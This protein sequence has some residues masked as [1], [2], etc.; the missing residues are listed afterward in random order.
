MLFHH[1]QSCWL[2]TLIASFQSPPSALR[3]LQYRKACYLISH[4][5]H[6]IGRMADWIVCGCTGGQNN[7]FEG[8]RYLATSKSCH[9][10]Q[11]LNMKICQLHHTLVRLYNKPSPP[12]DTN[13]W[14]VDWEW[15]Y[16]LKQNL[17]TIVTLVYRA[18]PISLAYWKLELGHRQ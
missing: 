5:W 4:E 16:W 12:C 17:T 14:S 8:T 3:Q 15:D 1:I 10:E 18:R 2:Y 7:K 9:S 11:A 13:S 6:G